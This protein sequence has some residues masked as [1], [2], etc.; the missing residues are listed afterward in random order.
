MVYIRFY[1]RY[2]IDVNYAVNQPDFI[3][4]DAHNS[5]HKM[6]RGIDGIVEYYDI[7]QNPAAPKCSLSTSR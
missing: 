2:A 5:L 1:L 7:A 4:G 3:P 6:N